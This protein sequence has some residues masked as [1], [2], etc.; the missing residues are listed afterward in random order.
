M[1]GHI[2]YRDKASQGRC[3]TARPFLGDAIQEE[4]PPAIDQVPA[5]NGAE[6][7]CAEDHDPIEED[8]LPEHE[9]E[10]EPGEFED[11]F[12]APLP[13][14]AMD[15]DDRDDDDDAAAAMPEALVEAPLLPEEHLPSLE[16]YQQKWG[17]V[18]FGAT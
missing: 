17:R 15:V 12:E 7:S 11:V 10:A 4:T 2:T 3:R 13:E 5:N 16:E 1:R 6:M 14:L 9:P 18:G 8:V